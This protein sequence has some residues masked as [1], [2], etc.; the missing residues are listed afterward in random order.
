MYMWSNCSDIGPDSD[1]L[2][3]NLDAELDTLDLE[4]DNLKPGLQQTIT[5]LFKHISQDSPSPVDDHLSMSTS[6]FSS[7]GSAARSNQMSSADDT[8]AQSIPSTTAYKGVFGFEIGFEHQV[9][10]TKA[11]AWTYSPS[12]H[13]MFVRIAAACPILFKMAMIPP[14]GSYIR[15]MPVYMKPEYIQEAV[16]RCANHSQEPD[17]HPAPK[18]LLR[19]EHKMAQYTEH[20]ISH[21]HSILLPAEQPQAGVECVTN[22]FQ[23]MC[24]SSCVG[25]LNRRSVQVVFTLESA[26]GQ[27]LGRQA[28]EVRICACPGRD[29]RQEEQTLQP[30]S[31]TQGPKSLKRKVHTMGNIEISPQKLR[32]QEEGEEVFTLTVVGFHNFQMISQIRDSLELASMVS[33]VQ[34]QQYRQHQADLVKTIN[35][36]Q[37]QKQVLPPA[38][39]ALKPTPLQ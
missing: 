24:F 21:R 11:T 3:G 38:K 15:A 6:S 9:K 14:S 35:G 7:C 10:D 39:S 25:G 20:P 12:L 22:L 18:H 30:E 31:T 2:A 8:A 32:Q 5:D 37:Q 23:F 19:C 4:H 17:G 36:R 34:I 16:K 13:K 28:V 1:A 26:E 27:V 29:R 33:N